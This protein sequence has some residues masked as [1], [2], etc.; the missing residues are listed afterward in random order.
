MR[1]LYTIGK[2]CLGAAGSAVIVA[3]QTTPDQATSNAALWVGKITGYL[4]N[5]PTQVDGWITLLGVVMILTPIGIWAYRKRNASLDTKQ[6]SGHFSRFAFYSHL[7]RKNPNHP[8]FKLKETPD[9]LIPFVALRDL[10]PEFGISLPGFGPGQNN[11]YYLEGALQQ[12]AVRGKLS[13]E[14][15]QHRKVRHNDP[16]IPVPADHFKEFGFGHG[17][18]NYGEPNEASHTGNIAMLSANQ[19]G[20]PDVTFYD[21]WL[22]EKDARQVLSEFAG[23]DQNEK[24]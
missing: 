5:W 9:R 3:M 18:L 23:S 8:L 13:V 14:G 22:S 17:I 10:A 1:S 16:L 21:L 6:V 2:W 20:I 24:P 19:R 15:R 4:P 12:A 7:F 11:A